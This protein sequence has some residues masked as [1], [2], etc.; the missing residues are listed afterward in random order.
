MLENDTEKAQSILLNKHINLNKYYGKNM[1]TLLHLAANN[2]NSV[3]CSMLI[4]NGAS[5]DVLNVNDVTP[6]HIAITHGDIKILNVL[7]SHG[8][9]IHRKNKESKSYLHVAA[10][11]GHMDLSKRILEDHQLDI[12]SADDKDGLQSIQQQRVVIGVC[13]NTLQ[14]TEVTF[15]AQQ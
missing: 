5:V 14:K 10:S 13:F 7:L 1:D 15:T 9:D 12:K 3:I 2:G 11:I 6:L 8:A 4:Q